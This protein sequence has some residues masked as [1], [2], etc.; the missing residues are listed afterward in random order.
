MGQS[1]AAAEEVKRDNW[2]AL[3]L[4][5]ITAFLGPVIG[6]QVV[7]DAMT[8]SSGYGTWLA[9]LIGDPDAPLLSHTMIALPAMIALLVLLLRRRILQVPNNTLSATL[10]LFFGVVIAS[11]GASSFRGVSMGACLEWLGYCGVF[12]GAVAG[13]GRR[14]GPVV[15]SWATFAGILLVA[16]RGIREY[17]ENRADNPSWRIFAGWSNPNAVAA[18]YLIGLFLG[19]GLAIS[20][21]RTESLIALLGTGFIG[22]AIVLTGSKG[23]FVLAAP[24][25][26][27]VFCAL[28]ARSPKRWVSVGS[29]LL[30]IL[31]ALI[32][33]VLFLKGVGYVSIAVSSVISL[34]FLLASKEDEAKTK[35]MKILAPLA[36]ATLLVGMLALTPPK[37]QGADFVAVHAPYGRVANSADTQEQ[38]STFRL[39]LWKGAMQLV[40]QNPIGS[41]IGTYRYYSSKPGLTTQTVFAHN[42]FLQLAAEASI[43]APILLMGA[44]AGWAVLVLRG[45][46][47]AA[48][49]TSRLL[50]GMVAAVAAL[51]IHN[52]VDSDLYYFGIGSTVFLL[53]GVGM[54]LAA[55]A[56]APE[57]VAKGLRWTSAAGV[58]AAGTCLAYFGYVDGLKGQAR[59]EIMRRDSAAVQTVAGLQGLAPWDGEVWT[60][61][62][63]TTTPDQRLAAAE[64]AVQL[65][66]STKAL[67]SLARLQTQAGQTNLAIGT[68]S[69]ALELDP[70][71]LEALF[72]KMNILAQSGDVAEATNTAQRLVAVEDTDY[73]KVRSIENIVP[74]QTY[75]A[76]VFLAKML[77]SDAQK[78]EQLKASVA[79][80]RQYT[81]ITVPALKVQLKAD[82]NSRLAGQGL[83]EAK[84]TLKNALQASGEL[85]D[86]YRAAGDGR[87]VTEAEEAG[88]AFSAA[89]AGLES[90]AK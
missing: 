30:P 11:I 8:M 16:L 67:R 4:L 41:G 55:D 20:R 33:G 9:G 85:R 89:L 51:L 12:Y 21:P 22:F 74:T 10:I 18:I 28:Q 65:A 73:F 81:D 31:V 43:I 44:F 72:L 42:S 59:Q 70:N 63:S 34:G 48:S 17:G 19:L 25:G 87:G 66:P 84:E 5:T 27:A 50:G 32:S 52:L 13:V 47:T 14:H 60:M 39:R 26:L 61:S 78:I 49:N 69:R 46:K 53:L 75:L 76:R 6:G 62:V 64:K 1:A 57:F 56:V 82:P 37:G 80:F 77:P 68:L 36:L 23:A 83:P 88:A 7:T 54:L 2:I 29:F 71:N 79:G 45:I 58:A 40:R 38:S 86:L 15:I 35:T 90:L 3:G 24:I